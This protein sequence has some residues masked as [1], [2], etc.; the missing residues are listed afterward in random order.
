MEWEIKNFFEIFLKNSSMSSKL[1]KILEVLNVFPKL[2]ITTGIAWH[3]EAHGLSGS[4][5]NSAT[6][7]SSVWVWHAIW[8]SQLHSLQVSVSLETQ[9]SLILVSWCEYSLSELSSVIS[10]PIMLIV[11]LIYHIVSLWQMTCNLLWTVY[12]NEKL[13]CDSLHGPCIPHAPSSN[14][15][16]VLFFSTKTKTKPLYSV[17]PLN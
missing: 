3:N 15:L 16:L 4:Q 2:F 14:I 7:I 10:V 1:F 6:W 9:V 17:F 5:L 12:A 8:F 11:T 13:V